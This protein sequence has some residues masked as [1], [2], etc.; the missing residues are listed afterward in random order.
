M[1]IWGFPILSQNSNTHPNFIIIY[2]EYKNGSI[3]RDEF[4]ELEMA[5]QY[6]FNARETKDL[7]FFPQLS[8]S[9][10]CNVCVCCAQ[11]DFGGHHKMTWL[12]VG[13]ND[14]RSGG[15]GGGGRIDERTDGR[16]DRHNQEGLVPCY[17]HYIVGSD[18]KMCPAGMPQM[19]WTM[20]V[21]PPKRLDIAVPC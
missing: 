20:E 8:P 9:A 21:H 12:L 19:N 14:Q 6:F 18:F 13:H 16:T 3:I 5:A 11:G 7:Y 1:M 2:M 4:S 17:I 10:V 15:V